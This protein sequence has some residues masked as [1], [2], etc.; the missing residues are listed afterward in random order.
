MG[1]YGGDGYD[2]AGGSQSPAGGLLNYGSYSLQNQ[3][4]WTWAS[5]TSDPRA[6]KID[7]QG[8]RMAATWYTNTFSF[9]V[10]LTDQNAHQVALYVL[11][12]DSQGRSET[13]QIVNANNSSDV[14]DT[15]SIPEANSSSAT[16]T[17]TI[18][19]NFVNG[20]Y[21]VWNI[22]GH[23]TITITCDGGPNAVVAGIFF[24]GAGRTAPLFTSAASTTFTAGQL[25]TFTV[26][27]T[28]TPTPS[29]SEMGALPT[30]SIL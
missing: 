22:T 3:A 6:L 15:R 24:G 9:D 10:N 4:E 5:S 11:D 12:W 27:T 29:L 13:V 1:T 14:L 19:T 18:G 28:G 20:A 2:I 17:N 21:L 23:V 26:T 7:A 8:D 16:Y 25:G 30:G